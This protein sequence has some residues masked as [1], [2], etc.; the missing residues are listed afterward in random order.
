[1][2]LPDTL[3]AYRTGYKTPIGMSP[4]RKSMPF[5]CGVGAQSL[6]GNQETQHGFRKGRNYKEIAVV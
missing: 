1:M 3:W 4:F 5:T 2:K 6:V